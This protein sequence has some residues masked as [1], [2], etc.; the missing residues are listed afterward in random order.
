MNK[1]IKLDNQNGYTGLKLS[2]GG[3][4]AEV[5]A[6]ESETK[7]Q[8]LCPAIVIDFLKEHN[9]K[10]NM[11]IIAQSKGNYKVRFHVEYDKPISIEIDL[12]S[13]DTIIRRI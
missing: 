1:Y 2:I 6:G 13:G 8:Y 12:I 5:V 10:Y 9:L 11:I 4:F 3:G 7:L